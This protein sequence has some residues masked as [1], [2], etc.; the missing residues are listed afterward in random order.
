MTNDDFDNS[1]KIT[2]GAL[3]RFARIDER[4]KAIQEE[5]RNFRLDVKNSI[6]NLLERIK[7]VEVRDNIRQDAQ[8]KLHDDLSEHLDKNYVKKETFSP[9]QHL[10]YGFVGLIITSVLAALISLVLVK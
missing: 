7:E 4:T 1:E 3:T 10:V 5:L 2:P 6:A 8:T 9:I